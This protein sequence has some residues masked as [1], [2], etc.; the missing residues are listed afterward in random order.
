M[1]LSKSISTASAMK[2]PLPHQFHHFTKA[3]KADANSSSQQ[4]GDSVGSL[5]LS[6]LRKL[7]SLMSNKLD[8][9]FCGSKAS[10]SPYFLCGGFGMRFRGGLL[11][12]NN[13]QHRQPKITPNQR[14]SLLGVSRAP[15]HDINGATCNKRRLRCQLE[16]WQFRNMIKMEQL[17]TEIHSMHIC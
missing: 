13:I 1:S 3:T 5:F 6:D 14:S 7:Q 10:L 11:L 9:I 16:V 12:S 8:F 4:R 15:K 17:S 2:T